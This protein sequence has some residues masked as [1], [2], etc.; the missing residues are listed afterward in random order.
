MNSKDM[1]I[2]LAQ[3]KKA[4]SHEE[5]AEIEKT[6]LHDIKGSIIQIINSACEEE[7]NKLSK[8]GE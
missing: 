4:A 2:L 7:L 3:H 6:V 8:E 1:Q 5:M